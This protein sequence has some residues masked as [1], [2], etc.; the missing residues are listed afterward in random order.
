V[1]NIK[2]RHCGLINTPNL[3]GCRRCG[4]LLN[5][6]GAEASAHAAPYAANPSGHQYSRPNSIPSQSANPDTPWYGLDIPITLERFEG[7]EI[8]LRSRLLSGTKLFMDGL[9]MRK[10]KNRVQL[11]AND[12]STVELRMKF[13]FVDPVPNIEVYGR[14]I[15]LLP[16]LE[17]TDH[18]WSAVPLI[19]IP[20]GGGIGGLCGGAACAIN[21][22]IFRTQLSKAAKFGITALVTGAAFVAW[23]ILALLF[24]ALLGAPAKGRP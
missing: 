10:K 13:R 1:T 11:R 8:V 24:T 22:Q 15:V 2:C 21:A 19:L 9:E 16:A 20:L 3:Q 7:H 17:I 23:L 18:I 12:G 14:T 5:L 6:K 4:A